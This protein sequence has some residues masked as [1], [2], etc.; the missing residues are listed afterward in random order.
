[1]RKEQGELGLSFLCRIPIA[2]EGGT[3]VRTPEE[4]ATEMAEIQDASQELFAVLFLNT[5]NRLLDKRVVGIG[6]ADSC[7]VHAREVFRP[8]ILAQSA[9]VILCHNHP[10]GDYSPSAEDIR[11]TRQLVQAGQV[12]GIKVL[13]HVIIGRPREGQPKWFLSLR[14]AGTV[15]F[16]K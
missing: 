3:M 13:D 4:A 5:R 14:E 7:L 15:E 12:V 1:M 11:L 10:S 9:A 16:D 6:V 2:R 8:A